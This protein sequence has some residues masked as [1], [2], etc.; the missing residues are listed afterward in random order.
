MSKSNNYNNKKSVKNVIQSGTTIKPTKG[1]RKPKQGLF[2]DKIKDKPFIVEVTDFKISND[3]LAF[4]FAHT[5]LNSEHPRVIDRITNCRKYIEA[6]KDSEGKG[7]VIKTFG[8]GNRFCPS[9]S[10]ALA[11][12]NSLMLTAVFNYLTDKTVSKKFDCYDRKFTSCQFIFATLTVPNCTGEELPDVISSM[13]AAYKRLF[14]RKEI[15]AISLGT[16]RKL[17]VTLNCMSEEGTRMYPHSPVE[18]VKS[19]YDLDYCNMYT[20][21]INKYSDKIANDPDYFAIEGYNFHPHFHVVIAVR[22]CYGGNGHKYLTKER[23]SQ[24]WSESMRSSEALVVDIRKVDDDGSALE[25]GK[26]IAKKE[27]YLLSAQVFKYFYYGLRYRKM[28]AYSGIFKACIKLFKDGELDKYIPNDYT[29]IDSYVHL[30]YFD[31]AKLVDFYESKNGNVC[32]VANEKYADINNP[33]RTVLESILSGNRYDDIT[34][35]LKEIMDNDPDLLLYIKDLMAMSHMC[36]EYSEFRFKRNDKELEPGFYF[37]RMS[38]KE[39]DEY[40]KNRDAY[41]FDSL[42]RKLFWS[43]NVTEYQNIIPESD[44]DENTNLVT[45]S[46][47][48]TATSDQMQLSFFIPTV[49]SSWDI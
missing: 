37:Y 10:R 43:F 25:V 26:Y 49:T 46:L 13:T 42:K 16:V 40:C 45:G 20:G 3:V 19:K 1:W 15:K 9:C 31:K 33:R 35:P 8:C 48:I 6:V 12:K 27:D 2:K 29:P 39:H 4:Y 7:H 18:G 21:V 5:G 36:L 38:K 34:M 41:F 22:N 47:N 32:L 30:T 24:L 44:E 28:L 11:M 23:L 17:E 14:E